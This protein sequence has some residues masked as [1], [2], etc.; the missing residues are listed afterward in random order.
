VAVFAQDFTVLDGSFGAVQSHKICRV[1]DLA[2]ESGI[3]LIG[4]NDSGQVASVVAGG[5]VLAMMAGG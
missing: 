5:V 1:Q 2:L 3:P 4:L